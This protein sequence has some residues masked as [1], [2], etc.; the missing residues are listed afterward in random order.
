MR[1]LKSILQSTYAGI[2]AVGILC[3]ASSASASFISVGGYD[4]F[5]ISGLPGGDLGA[6]MLNPANHPTFGVSGFTDAGDVAFGSATASYLSGV[7]MFFTGRLGI[8]SSPSGSDI[9]N[10]VNFVND[11][12]VLVINNDRSTSFTSLDPLLNAFGIDLVPLPTSSVE[13]LN[14]TDPA[15]PIM[16]GPFGQVLSMGLRDASRYLA[17]TP[18][19]TIAATWLNGD[20]AIA[21]L[22][23]GAGRQGAV[24]V[25]PDVERF[26]LDFD[27][28]LGTG[29]TETATLNAIAYGVS[30]INAP[31]VP[32]PGTL[33]VLG[34][35]YT[36]LYLVRRRK[37]R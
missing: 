12:G 2:A 34:L 26:L 3:A 10:L 5:D 22:G 19:V 16:D 18:D 24:I 11:G 9:T 33:A 35:R 23:P 20:S 15:H 8:T 36:G 32:E 21:T 17:L 27:S 25:L 14:I 37:L 30:V 31:T 28:S 4:S 29:D 13:T 7:D 1:K 6:A